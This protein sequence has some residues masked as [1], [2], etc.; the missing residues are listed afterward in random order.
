[1]IDNFNTFAGALA[2]ESANLSDTIAEL[3]PTLT[4]AQSSLA[5]LSESLP[6]LR[7]LA[8]VS[9]PG[10]DELPDTIDAFQPW[11][12][13]TDALVQNN[14][15]GGLAKLLRKTAPGLAQTNAGAKQLFP[16]VTALSRCSTQVLVPTADGT[17][18]ADSSWS[19]GQ[20]NWHEFFY[21]LTN[22]AGSG[23]GFDG[24]GPYLRVQP[25]GGP[26]LVQVPNPT[27]SPADQI[28]F[29]NTIET[30]SGIQPV[31]GSTP[32]FRMDYTCSKNLPPNLNG[33]S[34][35]AGPSD[36]VNSQ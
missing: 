21:G 16:E 8:R 5:N 34:A 18:T 26:Q 35:A 17:I 7:A 22:V 2:N 30:L 31:L 10:I 23:Q 4:Q 25:G 33:P 20:S 27:G 28:N 3:E 1:M 24:N 11:L 13:Q 29:T 36:L 15:L 14:E 6:P 12:V 9:V 32:P 19:T